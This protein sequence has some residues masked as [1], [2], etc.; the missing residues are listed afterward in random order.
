MRE[1]RIIIRPFEELRITEYYGIKQ[2]NEHA[3]VKLKGRFPLSI[4]TSICS[5]ESSRPGC[6]L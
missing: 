5:W 1:E 6:R 4:E 3:Q 2:V